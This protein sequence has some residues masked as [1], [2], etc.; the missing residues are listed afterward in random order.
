MAMNDCWWWIDSIINA[1]QKT[2]WQ[3][4]K[5]NALLFVAVVSFLGSFTLIGSI[6]GFA[7][8]WSIWAK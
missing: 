3:K 6:I 7:I 5:E 8:G 4:L 1:P 2:K